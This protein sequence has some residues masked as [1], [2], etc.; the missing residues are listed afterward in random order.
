M[1]GF[2]KKINNDA[3]ELKPQIPVKVRRFEGGFL[4]WKDDGES[5]TIP[6]WY[7]PWIAMIQPLFIRRGLIVP[8]ERADEILSN[9]LAAGWT[10]PN[11]PKDED[12]VTPTK[13]EPN[14]QGTGTT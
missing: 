1:F 9:L 3:E 2:G 5:Y 8:E 14:A 11:M 12:N 10:A 4:K 7:A 6:V 13:E